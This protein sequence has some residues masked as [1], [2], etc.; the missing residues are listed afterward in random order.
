MVFGVCVCFFFFK[1]KTAYEMR[2]SDWSSDVC[3]SDLQLVA[4]TFPG[5]LRNTEMF[6]EWEDRGW[7]LIDD[8]ANAHVFAGDD[9][10]GGQAFGLLDLTNKDV[11]KLWSE[12]LR[13]LFD[14]GVGA[15]AC[16]AQFNIP[17]GITA[18]GGESGAVLRTIY[19]LLRS[20]EH[21][22][23]LQSLM[24]ISYAVLC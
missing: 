21:T 11:F 19:P 23:E 22:T 7:L 1:Q 3:S 5:V 13:Q 16:D 10:S 17:D 9:V 24:R 14:E 4:P 20:E 6:D 12:R 8:E 18:R 2:I 15:A